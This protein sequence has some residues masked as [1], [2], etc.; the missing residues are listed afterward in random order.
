ML[1]KTWRPFTF[2]G[3]EEDLGH[4][5]SL[6]AGCFIQPHFTSWLGYFGSNSSQLNF[7][8]RLPSICL[9]SFFHHLFSSHLL[10]H[11]APQVST[12]DYPLPGTLNNSCFLQLRQLI[13]LSASFPNIPD[14]NIPLLR[15]HSCLFASIC[16]FRIV[17]GFVA[18]RSEVK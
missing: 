2:G 1:P 18:Q 4:V 10:T 5:W 14:A 6:G 16:S 3:G 13:H 7:L 12:I 9:K 17:P 11:V 15:T 8:S